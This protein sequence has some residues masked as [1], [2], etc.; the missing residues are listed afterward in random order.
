MV[1]N[2]GAKKSIRIFPTNIPII[3]ALQ[4]GYPDGSLMDFHKD[5]IRP[6]IGVAFTPSRDSKTVIRAGYGIYSNLVYANLPPSHEWRPLFGQR[7][8]PKRDHQWRASVQL[9]GPLPPLY[10]SIAPPTTGGCPGNQSP[11]QDAL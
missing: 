4:A 2:S 1:P 10:S 6:R 5:M 11:F 3:T 7:D 8:L 9:S